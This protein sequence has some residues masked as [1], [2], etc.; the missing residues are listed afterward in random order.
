MVWLEGVTTPMI[1]P[2]VALMVILVFGGLGVV[3]GLGRESGNLG[4]IIIGDCSGIDT[5]WL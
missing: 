1:G 2:G 4:A 3:R 5:T